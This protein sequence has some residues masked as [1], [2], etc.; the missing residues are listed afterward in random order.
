VVAP[1]ARRQRRPH[2]T[3]LPR[4]AVNARQ[5]APPAEAGVGAPIGIGFGDEISEAIDWQCVAARPGGQRQAVALEVPEGPRPY[6][7]AVRSWVTALNRRTEVL[8][9][10]RLE[11]GRPAWQEDRTRE[12]RS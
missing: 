5:A 6:L 11:G 9:F 8:T 12:R 10:A 4:A 1:R 3:H 2:T 7:R